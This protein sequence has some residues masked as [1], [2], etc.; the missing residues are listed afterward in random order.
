MNEK[1]WDEIMNEG[2]EG[3][4]PYRQNKKD[5][6]P[7]WSKVESLIAKTQRIINC[8]STNDSEWPRLQTKY[9]AL[10]ATYNEMKPF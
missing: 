2:G 4:N 6:E 5:S 8:T 7:T 3:Y 9:D 10:K 1:M